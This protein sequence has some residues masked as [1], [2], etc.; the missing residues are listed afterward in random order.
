[1]LKIT[2]KRG[3]L[4]AAQWN[5][6]EIHS[7]NFRTDRPDRPDRIVF[8]LDPGEGVSWREIAQA[9]TIVRIFLQQLG[10]SAF[11][12]TSGGKGLHVVSPI[13]RLHGWQEVERFCRAVVIHLASTFPDRMVAKL[14][15]KNRVGKIFI[16]YL[17][18]RAG[19]TTAC[20]W[21]A[22]ARPGMGVS[23]PVDW[24]ELTALKSS[25]PWTVRNI[26]Q[27]LDVGNEPWESYNRSARSLS[28]PLK[29][30]LGL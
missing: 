27:R 9:T 22:R 11:L 10:L 24:A 26:D 17:R 15:P 21:T 28:G 30:M 13:K 12:K 14:G 18:N 4:S 25:S 29:K 1:M 5:V 19:A 23:V 7:F 20:A 6:V 8:D 16:D 2:S 3:L